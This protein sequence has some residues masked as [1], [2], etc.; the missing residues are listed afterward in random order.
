M[1]T[2]NLIWREIARHRKRQCGDGTFSEQHECEF[3]TATMKAKGKSSHGFPLEQPRYEGAP[4]SVPL[5]GGILARVGSFLMVDI[6]DIVL[7][8]QVTEQEDLESKLIRV[9]VYRSVDGS[10]LAK[11]I[12]CLSGIAQDTAEVF[13][14]DEYHDIL[15]GHITNISFVFSPSEMERNGYVIQGISNAFVCRYQADGNLKVFNYCFPNDVT[16]YCSPRRSC[17]H[18]RIWSSLEHVRAIMHKALNKMGEKQGVKCMEKCFFPQESWS[19]I[20]DSVEMALS[21]LHE[22]DQDD[23]ESYDEDK[24]LRVKKHSARMKIRRT[25]PGLYRFSTWDESNTELLRFE[26]EEDLLV[27]RCIFNMHSMHGIRGRSPRIDE[28]SLKL[29]NNTALN[30]VKANLDRRE[31]LAKY[32]AEDGIDLN[33][34]TK[35]QM[36]EVRVRYTR[37]VYRARNGVVV[38]DLPPYIS[39]ILGAQRLAALEESESRRDEPFSDQLSAGQFFGDD[40]GNFFRV[41]RVDGDEVYV[42]STGRNA[43]RTL[44]RMDLDTVLQMAATTFNLDD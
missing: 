24:L 22:D 36:L 27:F 21:K 35:W 28:K 12:P 18:E 37:A 19:Y 39:R 6:E 7:V 17:Y 11:S 34:S 26:V 38:T 32:P 14:T 31:K 20:K 33:Y 8:A 5:F 2:L 16:N 43:K 3:T 25:G 13:Q 10:E 41:V 23:I 29:T 40:L 9:N 30:M 44:E 4:I 42:R 15:V 1:R